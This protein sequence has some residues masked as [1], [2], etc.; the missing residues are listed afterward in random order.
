MKLRQALNRP[1]V[2]GALRHLLTSM[3]P[4][5]AAHG[6]TTDGYWQIGVGVLMAILGFYASLTAKEKQNVD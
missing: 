1:K 2:M 3:G 6:V 5:L 4:L